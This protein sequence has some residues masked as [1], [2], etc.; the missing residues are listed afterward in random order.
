MWSAV[1]EMVPSKAGAAFAEDFDVDGDVHFGVYV[2]DA[3]VTGMCVRSRILGSAS[4]VRLP[5]IPIIRW[6]LA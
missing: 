4:L 3:G 1:Q 6:T 5:E 2:D